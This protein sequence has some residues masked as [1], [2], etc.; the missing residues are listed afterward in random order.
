MKNLIKMDTAAL[1]KQW[2]G[3]FSAQP[4]HR[5]SR[6][7]LLMSL[8]WHAQT[9]QKGGLSRNAN[10][11]IKALMQQLRDGR[12]ITPENK[13]TIKP[14]TKL[15]REYRGVKHEVIVAEGGYRYQG[16]IYGSLSAIARQITGTRWNGRVFFGVKQ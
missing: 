4:P 7:Y 5:A 15:L 6:E 2:V 13:L 11:Q 12:P 16:D 9:K 10:R 3:E 14:G 8:A 1:Q